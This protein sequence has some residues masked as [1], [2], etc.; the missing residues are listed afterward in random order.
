MPTVA[1]LVK[2]AS[3]LKVKEVPGYV[4]KFAAQHWTPA[5]L[6]SRFSTWL[7]NYKTQVRGRHRR[8]QPV[9]PT[10]WGSSEGFAWGSD[11][12]PRRG[13][14]RLTV[15]PLLRCRLLPGTCLHAV[16]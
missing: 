4:Q 1:N 6:Q 12:V 13:P 8:C 2:E 14:R 3:R 10:G 7:Q 11:G 5:Q 9:G 16:Y 15:R